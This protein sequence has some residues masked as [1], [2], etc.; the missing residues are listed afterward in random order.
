[1]RLRDYLQKHNV[2]QAA[3]GRRMSPPVSQSKVNHWISG[4]RRVSLV[5]ALQIQRITDGEVALEDL[6]TPQGN[7]HVQAAN[8]AQQQAA[9]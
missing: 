8:S 5:E 3:F 2:S 9:A 6:I 1:M 7:A 4:A